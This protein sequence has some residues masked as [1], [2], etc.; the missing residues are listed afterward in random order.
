MEL[1]SSGQSFEL[2]NSDGGNCYARFRFALT[3][4]LADVLRRKAGRVKVK[5]LNYDQGS[6]V[7]INKS[8]FLNL[9]TTHIN[10]SNRVPI[11]L[12][13]CIRIMS[14]KIIYLVLNFFYCLHWDPPRQTKNMEFCDNLLD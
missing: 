14:L 6:I 10:R 2:W 5:F 12:T 9:L 8:E 1:I 7:W 4:K 13:S 3:K 11:T